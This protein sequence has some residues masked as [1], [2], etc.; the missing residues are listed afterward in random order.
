MPQVLSRLILKAFKWAEKSPEDSESMLCFLLILFRF[1][2]WLVT[3]PNFQV[4]RA[5]C[6]KMM[7]NWIALGRF[8]KSF[9]NSNGLVLRGY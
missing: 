1:T 8:Q 5:L 9:A 2:G 7:A 3:F 4:L 6:R